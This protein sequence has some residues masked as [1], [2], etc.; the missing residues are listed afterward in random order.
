MNAMRSW[1]CASRCARAVAAASDVVDQD[2]IRLDPGRRPVEEDDR[3]P[4]RVARKVGVVAGGGDEQERIDTPAEQRRH[5]L[6]L[7]IRVLL[8]RSW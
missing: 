7:A 6:V 2:L 8:A 5:Q 3:R 4:G 1:P